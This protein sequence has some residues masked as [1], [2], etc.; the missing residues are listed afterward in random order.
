MHRTLQIVS[1]SGPDTR[2]EPGG[3]GGGGEGGGGGLGYL[4]FNYLTFRSVNDH[5]MQCA[6]I[7]SSAVDPYI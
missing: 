6:L 4:K 5:W 2:H 7:Q 3:G 1:N